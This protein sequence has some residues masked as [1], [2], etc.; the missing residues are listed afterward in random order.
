MSEVMNSAGGGNTG[1]GPGSS[2]PLP[3][4][5]VTVPPT[6]GGVPAPPADADAQPEA[7]FTQADVDRILKERLAAE[8][9]RAQQRA[10]EEK[11]KASGEWQ[12]VAEAQAARVQELEQTLREQQLQA[13]RIAAGAKHNLPPELAERLRGDTPEALEADAK[14]LAKLVPPPIVPGSVA[15]PADPRSNGMPAGPWQPPSWREVFRR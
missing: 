7:R 5:G 6:T 12:K 4:G 10:E 14:A 8:Q 2:A 13:W 9:R 1:G 3:A 11:A 15:Q